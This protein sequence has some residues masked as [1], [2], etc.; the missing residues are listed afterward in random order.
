LTHLGGD[1]IEVRSAGTESADQID[2]AATAAMAELGI[3]T[4]PRA[5]VQLLVFTMVFPQQVRASGSGQ[6]GSAG[7]VTVSS[8]PQL[9]SGQR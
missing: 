3:D 2:P 9:V 1:R 7:L 8:H 5:E 4:G 6:V